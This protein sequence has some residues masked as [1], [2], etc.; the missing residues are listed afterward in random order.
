[1]KLPLLDQPLDFSCPLYQTHGNDKQ[2]VVR[3]YLEVGNSEWRHKRDIATNKVH[4]INMNFNET[5]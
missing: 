5:V 2:S 1:M 4:G 3:Q